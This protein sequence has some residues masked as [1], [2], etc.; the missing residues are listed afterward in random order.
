M[1]LNLGVMETC[2]FPPEAMTAERDHTKAPGINV[3]PLSEDLWKLL[4]VK[5]YAG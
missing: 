2:D 1:T 4:Q 3:V 5:F